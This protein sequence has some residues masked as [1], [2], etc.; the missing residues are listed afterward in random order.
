MNIK[1]AYPTD[2]DLRLNLFLGIANWFIFLDHIPDNVMNLITI[3][4]FGFS[5]AAD[6]FIFISGYGAAVVFARIELERGAIVGSTRILKRGW[7][8]YAAY[9]V[10]FVTYIVAIGS[11]AAQYSAPDLINE[12]NVVDLIDHPIRILGHGLLLQS[13]ALNLDVL[14]LYTLLMLLF[15]PVLWLMLR[16]PDLTMI[17]SI[18]LYFAARWFDWNLSSF[19][20]GYWY[21]N[22][23]CWQLLFVFGAWTAL[24]N[25][26]HDHPILESPIVLYLAIAYL[27]FALVVTLATNLPEFGEF[28]PTWLLDAFN[29]NSKANL[30]PYR[31]LHFAAALFVATWFI[32]KDWPGLKWLVFDPLIKCG[33]QSL[34]VFCVGVFLAFIGHFTLMIS[35]GSVPT[36]ILV[37]ATGIAIMTLVAYYISWSKQQDAWKLLAQI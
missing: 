32:S 4:N 22:P 31:V 17:G 24:G 37:S 9:I 29:P 11:V 7:Q 18:V 26:R 15:A 12:F 13:R 10:L 6:W 20:D 14:Q 27:I 34:A 30:P 21:F 3:R 2:D 33:E 25:V 36:Q 23:Y 1:T 8:L 35:S 28:F 5:G 19:P 16:K